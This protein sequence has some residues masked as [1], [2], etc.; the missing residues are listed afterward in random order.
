MNVTLPRAIQRQRL[1]ALLAPL[2]CLVT[3]SVLAFT[4][5]A[6]D[7][8]R[9]RDTGD[10]D[11]RGRGGPTVLA[12]PAFLINTLPPPRFGGSRIGA[13]LPGV[14]SPQ[15]SCTPGLY[16]GAPF[17]RCWREDFINRNSTSSIATRPESSSNYA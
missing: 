14:P 6:D 17:G 10:R 3:L 9:R 16:S 8:Q 13:L 15:G 11:D 1:A 12:T 5:V 4:A 7:G 2:A